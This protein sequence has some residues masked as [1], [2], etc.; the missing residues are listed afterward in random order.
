MDGTDPN[1]ANH[2]IS[3][4]VSRTE[5]F[6]GRLAV[7]SLEQRGAPIPSEIGPIDLRLRTWYNPDAVAAAKAAV[8]DAQAAVDATSTAYTAITDESRPLA[9]QINLIHLCWEL[10]EANLERAQVRRDSLAEDEETTSEGLDAAEATV[11]DAQDLVD[12]IADA[13][14]A[15]NAGTSAAQLRALWSEIQQE[16]A[17][18]AAS[19]SAFSELTAPVNETSAVVTSRGLTV[20]AGPGAE[21]ERVGAVGQGTDV[22]LNGRNAAGTWVRGRIPERTFEGEVT[23]IA[24]EAE[25]TPENVQ[26]EEQRAKLVFAVRISLDNPE[27]LLKPGMPADATILIE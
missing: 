18:L 20:R 14:D 13:Y 1:T 27:H 15:L 5:H 16:Q 22:V 9:T 11:E 4:I 25:F 7:A 8:E 19:G 10:A 2:A 12:A 17:Q 6:S 26:T 3:H 23:F 24:Q 21:Y